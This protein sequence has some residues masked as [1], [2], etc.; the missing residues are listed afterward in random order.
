MIPYARHTVDT[1]D[2]AAVMA[3]V[4]SPALTQGPIVER[5]E[6]AVAL[7]AFGASYGSA[8]AVSSGTAALRCML[9][10]INAKPGSAVVTSPLT[11][12]ATAYAIVA[13]GFRPVFADIG[14]DDLLLD[15]I[16]VDELVRRHRA[17]AVLAVD[18]AGN[19]CDYRSLCE[20]TRP[21]TRAYLLSDSAHAFGA[22]RAVAPIGVH[23]EAAAFSFHPAKTIAAG[24]G[25]AV[26]TDD[27]AIVE[28]ARRFRNHGRLPDGS[29]ISAGENYRMSELHAA[30]ALSQLQRLERIVRRRQEICVLYG[31]EL[32][33][34]SGLRLPYYDNGSAFHLYPVRVPA[35]KRDRFRAALA[36]LGI[37]TQ[38]H[39]RLVYEHPFY[40]KWRRPCPVAER[41]SKRLVSIP[42]W[43]MSDT[44]ADRVVDGVRKAARKVL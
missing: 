16:A 24:E 32:A 4:R 22:T 19:L 9:A 29:V 36:D 37:G 31:Q 7:A 18:Y 21:N 35:R 43:C 23:V 27:S 14:R 39:Y 12:A 13:A 11:F 1:G 26:V 25:G 41:E 15:P 20:F 2:V 3:A 40:A 30:L 28:R 33:G 5:F 44:E 6:K 34:I 38:I 17:A 8:V 42:L 10:G